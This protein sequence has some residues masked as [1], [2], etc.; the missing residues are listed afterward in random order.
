ME[1]LLLLA[2]VGRGVSWDELR[3]PI[4][5]YPPLPSS[6]PSAPPSCHNSSAAAASSVPPLTER[7]LK[8]SHLSWLVRHRDL[9]ARLTALESARAEGQ[10]A[11]WAGEVTERHVRS[12]RK[13][14]EEAEWVEQRLRAA[15]RWCKEQGLGKVPVKRLLRGSKEGPLRPTHTSFPPSLLDLPFPLPSAS[16]SNNYTL[17]VPR[18]PRF[19]DERTSQELERDAPPVYTVEADRARGE[20]SIERGAEMQEYGAEGLARL[21]SREEDVVAG[22]PRLAGARSVRN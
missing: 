11:C 9:S 8:A 13:A 7:T 22:E 2:I 12:V 16:S 6:S 3:S 17:T 21:G 18:P 5:P 15:V 14:R 10:G 1:S 20:M 4:L 19:D